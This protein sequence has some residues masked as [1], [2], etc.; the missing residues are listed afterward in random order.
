MYLSPLFFYNDDEEELPYQVF[1][2]LNVLHSI[3]AQMREA[4]IK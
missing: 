2:T 3:L 1:F 4:G